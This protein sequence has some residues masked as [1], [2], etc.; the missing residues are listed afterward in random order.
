MSN[1]SWRICLVTDVYPPECGGS[2]WSTHALARMLLKRGHQTDVISLDPTTDNITHRSF[3]GIEVTDVGIQG[4]RRNPI[5]RLGAHDYSYITCLLYTSP[6][7]R[8]S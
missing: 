3:E 7:P 8:D 2:G 4:S 5:R 1:L 6:S